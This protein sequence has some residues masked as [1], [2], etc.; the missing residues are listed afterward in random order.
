MHY[1]ESVL[2]MT[3]IKYA[4]MS[5]D[6]ETFSLGFNGIMKNV[7]GNEVPILLYNAKPITITERSR[8]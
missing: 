3:A 5:G 4:T 7:H 2:L 1:T 8:S 6:V